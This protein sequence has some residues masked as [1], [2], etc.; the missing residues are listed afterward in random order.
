MKQKGT[1]MK[2]KIVTKLMIV[3][4]GIAVCIGIIL[5]STILINKKGIADGYI[6]NISGKERMLSQRISKEV[7]IIN[8]QDKFDFTELDKAVSE[9]QDGLDIL[10]HGNQELSIPV[11]SHVK[12]QEQLKIID[13]IWSDF[14]SN[15]YIFK[16]A[17]LTLN[18]DKSFLDKNNNQMLKLSDNVVKAMVEA[19]LSGEDVDDSGRQRM[20]TQRMAYH[21]MRYT[22]KWDAES[23][24]SFYKS[25][26]LYNE[27]MLRFYTSNKYNSYPA[28]KEEIE[29]TYDFW[30]L[31]SKHVYSVLASQ[32]KVVDALNIIATQNNELL[33]EVDKVVNMYTNA[34]VLKRNYLAKFQYASI[35]IMFLIGLY[36]VKVIKNIKEVFDEFIQKSKELAELKVDSTLTK[37]KVDEIVLMH[38]ENELSEVSKNISTFVEKT[39]FLS[40]NS[41]KAKELNESITKEITMITEDVIR[42]INSSNM[43]E[44]EKEKIISE[45]NLSEDIAI[46]TSEELITTSKLLERLKKSLDTIAKHYD[47]LNK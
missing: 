31:Y 27:T 39:K 41:N 34:S 36:S 6:V 40:Q 35:F 13:N 47:T 32:K 25:F 43:S 12:I 9:F 11:S 18:D 2:Q 33:F 19:G 15:I 4:L 16:S 20:L 26:V 44:E 3:G 14:K 46:Q 37:D 29:K 22:N 8:S 10:K 21:L 7:F 38:G 5:F 30:L 17:L 28:L 1:T 42:S 45:V 23:Y 24:E